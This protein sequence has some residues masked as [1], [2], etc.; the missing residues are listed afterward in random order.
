[1]LAL[2]LLVAAAPA[3]AAPPAPDLSA[4]RALPQDP[5][6]EE[7]IRGNHYWVSN[8]E[9]PELFRADLR[10]MGG[11]GVYVGVGGEQNFVFAG[12]A[13]PDVMVLMDFD[14][15]IPDLHR[16][17][18][19]IFKRAAT[20]EQFRAALAYK[21]VRALVAGVKEDYPDPAV[22]ARVLA[23]LKEARATAHAHAERIVKGFVERRVPTFLNDDAM[24]ARIRA[25]FV[26][27]RVFMVRGDL[28][29]AQTMRAIGD[30][31]KRAGLP[32]HVL[33]MS[34]AEQ[35]FPYNDDFRKNVLALPFDEKSLVLRTI[36]RRKWGFA[37]GSNAYHYDI[38]GGLSFQSFVADPRTTSVSTVLAAATRA[39]GVSHLFAPP[40]SPPSSPSSPSSPGAPIPLVPLPGTAPELTDGAP[41]AVA[42]APAPL[43]CLATDVPQMG[44]VP[45][46]PFLRGTDDNKR[47]SRSSRPQSTVWVQTFYMDKYEVTYAEYKACEA[48]KKCH[49]AGPNYVDFN[50]P[51]QPITGISWYDAKQYCEAHGKRLP[52]E[53]EWE[54]AAR[55]TD[56]RRFPW[57]NEPATC[58]RTV[59]MTAAG[60]S[61][62]I[63]QKSKSH[64]D[65]GRP[66][67]VGTRPPTLY[68]LYD[69]AGN[70]WEWV[71]DWF[72]ES[73]A[74]CGADC[75]GVDPKGPCGGAEH[76][77][78]HTERV[79]RG[80]SW[81]WPAQY[82]T[83]FHRR[84]HTPSNRPVFHHFGFRCAVS[85]DGAKAL[86]G[87]SSG[88]E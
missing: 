24:Y 26:E 55:G 61:C 58:A 35:Y 10:K 32:V 38:Q 8:E 23:V 84:P 77:P 64:A 25:L 78:G 81:Y 72:S 1:M 76:C 74:A 45:G 46:G 71:A 44:C 36:S 63:K 12:W 42:G 6:P 68:G 52:T 11:G 51:K 73:W 20:K 9:R 22:R 2:A 56:G 54:K 31:A 85:L 86:A 34:N 70:S 18:A 65:V 5:A 14:G 37:P 49:H 87:A 79:V 75:A 17:Y 21:N 28:T 43:P 88:S 47:V 30:A 39:H 62:G 59:I 4:F 83:T 67:P 41:A 50:A 27:G 40:S 57:G 29:A 19:T 60:R 3:A 33:Y 69:M 80:G 16:V 53:A 7:L 48:D 82:A 13:K 15:A 66:D